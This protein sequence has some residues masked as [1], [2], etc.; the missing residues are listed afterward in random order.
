MY[1]RGVHPELFLTSTL[2]PLSSSIA[3]VMAVMATPLMKAITLRSGRAA[4]P[5]TR[6]GMALMLLA[7]PTPQ[8]MMVSALPVLLLKRNTFLSGYWAPVADHFLISLMVFCGLLAYPL[9]GCQPTTI[10]LT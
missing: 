2:A 3:M 6:H 10:L 7:S 9:P 1:I 8:P 5:V 4:T